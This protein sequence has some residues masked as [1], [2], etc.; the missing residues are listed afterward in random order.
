MDEHV[1]GA[2]RKHR[3]CGAELV[4]VVLQCFS[5]IALERVEP[6]SIA[7]KPVASNPGTRKLLD[8]EVLS[9]RLE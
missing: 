2:P 8:S 9:V 7:E 3:E 1:F 5:I 6:S 4:V